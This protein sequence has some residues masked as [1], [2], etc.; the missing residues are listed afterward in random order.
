MQQGKDEDVP[1]PHS[2]FWAWVGFCAGAR[3]GE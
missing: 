1:I 3:K 2:P